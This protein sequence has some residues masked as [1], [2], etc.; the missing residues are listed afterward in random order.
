MGA[1]CTALP[2]HC[3]VTGGGL[4]GRG[5]LSIWSD[6]GSSLMP[7]SLGEGDQSGEPEAESLPL[8]RAL[9]KS[10]SAAPAAAAVACNICRER[11][12]NRTAVSLRPRRGGAVYVAQCDRRQ[13]RGRAQ[14]VSNQRTL[15]SWV[16]QANWLP[17][18][19][20]SSWRRMP[21][22]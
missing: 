12:E 6:R 17:W 5:G 16:S 15:G 7:L 4:P 9:R 13:G 11:R 22:F 21:S 20:A 18:F 10:L 8:R 3:A 1:G 14:R 19:P 2:L